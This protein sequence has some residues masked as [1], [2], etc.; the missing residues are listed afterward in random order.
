MLALLADD[1][2]ERMISAASLMEIAIKH[3]IGKM[4]LDETLTRQGMRDLRMT[5]IPFTPQHAY[6][7][8]NLPHHHRDPFDRMLIATAL[9]EDIPLIGAVPQFKKYKG[10]KVIW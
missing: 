10:L 6:K 2:T 4:G 8:F 1:D 7:L 5:I 9:S 3:G